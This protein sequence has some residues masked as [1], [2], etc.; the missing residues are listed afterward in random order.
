MYIQAPSEQQP[1]TVSK[2]NVPK[3]KRAKRDE[4]PEAYRKVRFAKTKYYLSEL[5]IYAIGIKEY[6][7]KFIR[8]GNENDNQS[9]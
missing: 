6:L 2:G 5:L 8:K 3:V 1:I 9:L 7:N 4:V